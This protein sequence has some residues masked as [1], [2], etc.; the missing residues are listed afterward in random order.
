MSQVET[1]AAGSDAV[2]PRSYDTAVLEDL[3]GRYNANDK[4]AYDALIAIA[5]S[6]IAK[7]VH[8]RLRSF[9]GVARWE[10]SDDVNQEVSLRLVNA[11]KGVTLKTSADLHAFS[12]ELIRRVL[13][14]LV[15]R[16]KKLATHHAS[17]ALRDSGSSLG[18][19]GEVVPAVGE[20][21]ARLAEW[22]EFLEITGRLS[23]TLKELFNLRY[24]QGLTRE[25]AAEVLGITTR[26]VD[27]QWVKIRLELDKLLHGDFPSL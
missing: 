4:S 23:P 2:R 1:H 17:N 3:L 13:L 6:R 16:H 24:F 7:L 26:S 11:L 25:E 14:D 20:D 8:G 9:P 22:S 12:A 5:R 15:R 10:E 18:N 27:R 19:P 21:P